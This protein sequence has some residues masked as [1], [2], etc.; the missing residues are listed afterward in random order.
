MFWSTVLGGFEILGHWQAW[1]ALIFYLFANWARIYGIRLLLR[2]SESESKTFFGF[3]LHIIGGAIFQGILISIII[4]YLAPIIMFGGNEATS[5]KS[6][7]YFAWPIAKAGLI[8]VV[9]VSIIRFIPMIG[10]LIVITPGLDGFIEGVI[11]FRI[12]SARFVDV[13]LENAQIS[14]NIY[15]G[16]WYSIGYLIIAMAFIWGVL[17]LCGAVKGLSSGSLEAYFDSFKAPEIRII[18]RLLSLL[19]LFMYVQYSSQSLQKLL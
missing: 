1:L 5:L 18:A 11:I 4:F 8:A 13:S 17:F 14:T 7:S 3:A 6:F 15:P 9:S 12:F 2:R 16:V 10:T 19:P